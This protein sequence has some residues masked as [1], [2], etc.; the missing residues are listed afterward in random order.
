M[1]IGETKGTEVCVA[2]FLGSRHKTL[3]TYYLQLQYFEIN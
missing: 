3:I 2:V 1:C